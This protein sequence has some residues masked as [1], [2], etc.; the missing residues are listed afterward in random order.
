MKIKVTTRQI[1]ILFDNLQLL[2]KGVGLHL[3]SDL[4]LKII[5]KN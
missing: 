4:L 5:S 3:K 1:K 2:K